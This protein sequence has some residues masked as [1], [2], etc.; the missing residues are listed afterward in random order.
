MFP[1]FFQ[2]MKNNIRT[3]Q[4]DDLFKVFDTNDRP[5]AVVSITQNKNTQY[6]KAFGM[7]NLEYDLPLTLD[8]VTNAGSVS[9]QFTA[10]A[11]L[12]LAREGKI[13]LDA[14]VKQHLD[15]FP[16]FDHKVTVRHM[17]HHVSGL[18]SYIYYG[19]FNGIA[20]DD[21]FTQDTIVTMAKKQRSLNFEPDTFYTYCNSSYVLL[22][23]IVAKVAG[24]SFRA[25]AS[26]NIFKPL[27]MKDTFFHDTKFEIIKNKAEAYAV[28]AQGILNCPVVHSSYGGAN[29]FTTIRDMTKW[30][31]ELLDP[32]IFPENTI[33]EAFT[34]HVCKNGYKTGYG[35]GFTTGRYKGKKYISHG[36]ADQGYRAHISIIPEDKTVVLLLSNRSDFNYITYSEKALDIA[37]GLSKDQP[38]ENLPAHIDISGTY[39]IEKGINILSFI[40]TEQGTFLSWNAESIGRQVFKKE[41]NRYVISNPEIEFVLGQDKKLTFSYNGNTLCANK[42]VPTNIPDHERR[43]AG[44]YIS[45]EFDS[46]CDVIFTEDNVILSHNRTGSMPYKKYDNGIYIDAVFGI[47][48]LCFKND[49]M[50]LSHNRAVNVEFVK[51]QNKE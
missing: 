11:I 23:E 37:L 33:K 49:K 24:K 3:Q 6:A 45:T 43:Y 41:E 40:K 7:A 32:V 16:D 25:Y 42:I 30:A 22:A 14:P 13:D 31:N 21:V 35:Y 15:Y 51:I 38:Y 39:Y 20:V 29:L 9:K 4:L 27:G 48:A 5:G 46:V 19:L 10:F 50:Y 47:V 18:R 8:S 2:L 1:G 36:G 26:D 17:I 28:S 44:K 34:P 12:L